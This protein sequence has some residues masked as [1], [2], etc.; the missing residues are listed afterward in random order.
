MIGV[1]YPY[2]YDYIPTYVYTY[3]HFHWKEYDHVNERYDATKSGLV[4]A[5]FD[6]FKFLKGSIIEESFSVF[7]C[8]LT[9][10]PVNEVC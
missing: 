4:A 9:R 2:G 5:W 10:N 3:I 1:M 6:V 8:K 7:V